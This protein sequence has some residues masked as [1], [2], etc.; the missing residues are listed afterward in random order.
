MEVLTSLNFDAN[1]WLLGPTSTG[2]PTLV[3]DVKI[4][5]EDGKELSPCDSPDGDGV[6][7]SQLFLQHWLLRISK[8]IIMIICSLCTCCKSCKW[9][10]ER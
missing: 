10:L 8:L 2:L 9:L 3:A 6:G 1:T 5:D 4:C 7:E